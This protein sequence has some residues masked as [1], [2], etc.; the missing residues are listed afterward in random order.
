MLSPGEGCRITANTHTGIIANEYE[1][2]PG[3]VT[4]EAGAVCEGNNTSNQAGGADF[5]SVT[6]GTFIGVA[7]ERI[8]RR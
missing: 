3:E 8:T 4:V 5:V 7:E 6:G 2:S 1:G